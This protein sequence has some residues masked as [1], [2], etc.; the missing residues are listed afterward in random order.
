[1]PI[2]LASTKSALP[3]ILKL[4]WG[5]GSTTTNGPLSAAAAVVCHDGDDSIW[6]GCY[7]EFLKVIHKPFGDNHAHSPDG[8][9]VIHLVPGSIRSCGYSWNPRGEMKYDKISS[10][11]HTR[12]RTIAYCF[13]LSIA[14]V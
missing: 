13:Y 8:T 1:M 12:P 4:V 7:E 9:F 5:S 10:I 6:I 3:T 14:P 2:L 11:V